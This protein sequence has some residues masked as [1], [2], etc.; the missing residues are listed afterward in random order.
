MIKVLYYLRNLGLGG[1]EKTAILFARHLP[2]DRFD[3]AF[4]Y[5]SKGQQDRFQDLYDAEHI[6]LYRIRQG[7]TLPDAAE[8]FQADIFH[9]FR[10]GY[11]EF[12]QPGKDIGINH[13]FVETNVFGFHD[14]SPYVS[15][16][17]FMSEWLMQAAGRQ[18]NRRFDFVNNPVLKPRTHRNLD[19]NLPHNTMVLGRVG[20][21]DDGIY[22]PIAV[23]AS[24]LAK[25]QGIPIH[26]VVVAPPPRMIEDLDKFGLSYTVVEPT[27]DPIILS[28]AY[29][30]M[31]VYAH[32][33]ADGETF[34]VNIAEAMMHEL[35]V[36]T[37][38]ATP[39]HPGMGVFQSQTTLVEHDK[40]GL[41]TDGSVQS[42]HQA[43][44]EM[45]EIGSRRRGGLGFEGRLKAEKEYHID[46]VIAKLAGIYEELVRG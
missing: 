8:D 30:S 44:I 22:T 31:D 16:T 40:T 2:R 25:N 23:Q 7:V 21:P 38:K 35:P 17:L 14:P 29:N 10:S 33:R 42:Y 13:I 32:H 27:V 6:N 24:M 43:I 20:R 1:T 15:K 45:W 26:W 46:P 37:H 11:P 12:P 39:S 41:L 19:L 28:K 9:A 18:P 3:V 5:E 4:A 34:G 36:I